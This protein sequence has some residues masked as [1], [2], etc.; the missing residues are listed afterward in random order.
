[1]PTPKNWPAS[2]SKPSSLRLATTRLHREPR[3][4]LIPQ[5]PRR[6]STATAKRW[7]RCTGASPSLVSQRR[8][9]RDRVVPLHG[10][11]RPH[12]TG[13][14]A[15]S[16]FTALLVMFHKWSFR[17]DH[18]STRSGRWT[19]RLLEYTTD[20]LKWATQVVDGWNSAEPIIPCRQVV[21]RF[22]PLQSYRALHTLPLDNGRKREAFPFSHT[23]LLNPSAVPDPIGATS[24]EH[25]WLPVSS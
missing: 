2:C 10:R 16:L 15:A 17:D 21:M 5:M 7:N 8:H 14:I 4:S 1:M 22:A 23:E 19:Y 3:K 18:L 24:N 9:V 20:V 12:W 13:M 6:K 25:D 11:H